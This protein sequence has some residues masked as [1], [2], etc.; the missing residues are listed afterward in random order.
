MTLN[1][2]QLLTVAGGAALASVTAACGGATTPVIDTG[3]ALG[4]SYDGPRVTISFWNGF[5]GGD[6]PAMRDLVAK[7]NASQDRITVEQNTVQWAQYYQRVVAAIHAGRGPDVG[8][9]HLEQLATQAARQTVNPLDDVLDELGLSSDQFPE[10]VWAGGVVDDVRYGIPLDM[11]CLAS[12][13][14]RALLPSDGAAG[15]PATGDELRTVL[16]AVTGEGVETPF[17]MPNRWPAHLMFLSLLWQFGGEPYAADGSKA[18]FDS[19]AGV[20]ALTWMRS[21]IED[22]YS[23]DNVAVDTQ[24]TAFK[25]GEG[26]FTWDGIW[27]I[28]DL[29]AAGDELDW[30]IAPIPTIGDQPA[31]WANSHQLVLFR[32]RSPDDDRL[33][34]GKA[35]LRFLTEESAAW[36]GA[37]MIPARNEA[38]ETAEFKDSPQSALT[39][40]IPAMR[41]L[42]SVPGVPDVQA[43]TLE[44]AVSEAVLGRLS[45][46]EALTGAAGRATQLLEANLD[47]FGR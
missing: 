37:G 20:E 9:M 40:A 39:A 22:G 27:Q 36:T 10:K 25:N 23:P 41:F 7:F 6:G 38:R 29:Q 17:W 33:Q 32:D 5:T 1:R 47:K 18:L 35:F 24:Y 31:V 28:N 3:S 34:A 8:A 14:N 11:H 43:Q 15:R 30:G 13:S 19:D 44:I 12:Y 4:S 46:A 21:Q 45:P 26:A 2:R 42:P 16:D